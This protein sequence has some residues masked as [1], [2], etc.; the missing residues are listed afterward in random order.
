MSGT[1]IDIA[2]EHPLDG[3]RFARWL[4]DL[5][6]VL[7]EDGLPVVVEVE[8]GPGSLDL[9]WSDPELYPDDSTFTA[10]VDGFRVVLS[11]EFRLPRR[12]KD[13][14][15]LV[16]R[17]LEKWAALNLEKTTTHQEFEGWFQDNQEWL[18][19]NQAVAVAFSE[20]LR[21]WSE[22]LVRPLYEGDPAWC[23]HVRLLRERW[24]ECRSRAG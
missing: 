21:E 2:L 10:P 17:N 1:F 12:G 14:E 16:G 15:T 8:V 11:G 19:D 20:F 18:R 7:G 4:E 24:V 13:L 23:Y 6:E 9:N 22:P 3:K 5:H